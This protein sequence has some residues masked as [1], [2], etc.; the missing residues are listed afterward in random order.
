M[1][2]KS[3]ILTI[4]LVLVPGVNKLHSQQDKWSEIVETAIQFYDDGKIDTTIS[5]CIFCLNNTK[6]LRQLSLRKTTDLYR[7]AASAYLLNNQQKEARIYIKKLLEIDPDYAKRFRTDDFTEFKTEVNNMLVVPRLKYG[8]TF[9]TNFTGIREHGNP[10]SILA[11]PGS[12]YNTRSDRKWSSHSIVLESEEGNYSRQYSGKWGYQFGLTF[13][14]ILTRKL[15]ISATGAIGKIN[16]WYSSDFRYKEFSHRYEY[17]QQLTTSIG[18]M[19]LKYLYI[20]DPE[21]LVNLYVIGGF[22]GDSFMNAKRRE[23]SR[24]NDHVETVSEFYNTGVWTVNYNYIFGTGITFNFNRLFGKNQII[25]RVFI[26]LDL[27]HIKYLSVVNKPESRYDYEFANN[28][29]FGK[30][31]VMNDVS[32]KNLQL[33]L[34]VS[35][36][37]NYKVFEK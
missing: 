21:K 17:Y 12:E 13:D 30:Y 32:L 20:S 28:Y 1:N 16:Y 15:Y 10:H 6:T 37:I 2:R 19:M 23:G 25:N 4:V 8:L 18:N 35:W 3:I 27:K 33:S 7:L 14:Y 5:L 11:F 9:G 26:N 34:S 22:G 36:P 31:D 29:V 24:T